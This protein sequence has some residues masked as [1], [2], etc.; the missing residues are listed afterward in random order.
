MVCVAGSREKNHE[1]QRNRGAHDDQGKEEQDD[2]QENV[3][4]AEIAD[5]FLF[6]ALVLRFGEKTFAGPVLQQTR[7]RA[8]L[9][10]RTRCRLSR[11]P[12]EAARDLD[13]HDEHGDAGNDEI[14]QDRGIAIDVAKEDRADTHVAVHG[15]ISDEGKL[16]ARETPG[17]RCATGGK[18]PE[19]PY[20]SSLR[21]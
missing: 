4:A 14:A 9:L 12:P 13:Q 11:F 10:R 18:E 8:G 1:E 2:P 3:G 5:G 21:D 20:S 16:P 17:E 6:H 7:G 19:K 15:G